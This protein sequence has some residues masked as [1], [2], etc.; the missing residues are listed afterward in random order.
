MTTTDR[1][2]D[3]RRRVAAAGVVATVSVVIGAAA[4]AATGGGTPSIVAIALAL[5]VSGAIGMGVVGARPGRVRVAFGVVLDQ[6][7]FHTLFAFFGASGA[8]AGPNGGGAHASHSTLSAPALT[9]SAL[10]AVAGASTAPSL[11]M[12]VTHLGAAIIAYGMLHRG[13][14]AVDAVAAALV[15]ALERA[16]APHIGLPAAVSTPRLAPVA[17]A[18]PALCADLVGL[19]GRR[20]PPA[21][22][23]R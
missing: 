7:V 18:R 17:E 6:A 19:P 22:A 16:L 11:A 20:G 23:A 8:V 9:P 2:A 13:M 12:V 10:D 5:L 1:I 14:S 21:L 15:T 3:R 4:H